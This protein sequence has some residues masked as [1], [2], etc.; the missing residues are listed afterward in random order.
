MKHLS[1]ELETRY[2]SLALMETVEEGKMLRG[3]FLEFHS[4]DAVFEH[5][6]SDFEIFKKYF[7]RLDGNGTIEHEKIGDLDQNTCIDVSVYGLKPTQDAL[8]EVGI[9]GL[10]LHHSFNYYNKILIDRRTVLD[11]FQIYDRLQK[12]SKYKEFKSKLD[13]F[14]SI[15][16]EKTKKRQETGKFNNLLIRY[17]EYL[18]LK[19]KYEEGFFDDVKDS[20]NQQVG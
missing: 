20:S 15:E 10:A 18:T 9:A 11:G 13:S 12:H 3:K 2:I 17:N 7:S 1:I 14:R 4:L 5:I 8:S 16:D 19:K 6:Y